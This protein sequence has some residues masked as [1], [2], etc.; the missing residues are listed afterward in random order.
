M[1]RFRS[2]PVIRT[3][4]RRGEEIGKK[5]GEKWLREVPDALV[6]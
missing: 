4:T 3:P 5:V 1:L 6:V 2:A